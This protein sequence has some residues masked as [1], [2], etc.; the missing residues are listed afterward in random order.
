VCMYWMNTTTVENTE[1]DCQP[2]WLEGWHRFFEETNAE[3]F[4][5]GVEITY[6]RWRER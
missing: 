4:W 3:L 6:G 1:V 2:T 5:C